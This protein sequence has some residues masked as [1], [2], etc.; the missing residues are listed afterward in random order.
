M[1]NHANNAF[2]IANFM[3]KIKRDKDLHSHEK[4]KVKVNTYITIVNY[5]YHSYYVM[6]L[7]F[8]LIFLTHNNI[9]YTFSGIPFLKTVF[10][11]KSA[12]GIKL[13]TLSEKSSGR[14]SSSNVKTLMSTQGFNT[15][16]LYLN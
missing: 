16:Q 6:L 13:K 14:K 7:R 12:K 4:D 9:F 1:R 5:C 10:K 15:C 3:K 11:H 2:L 8:S